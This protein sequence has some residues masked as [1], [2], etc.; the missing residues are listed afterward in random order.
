M[1]KSRVAPVKQLS[2]PQLELIAGLLGA[3]LAGHVRRS[4]T[5]SGDIETTMWSDSQIVLHW[6]K[7]RRPLKQ[8]IAN[9]VKEINQLT[10]GYS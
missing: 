7:T 3:R 9:R 1:A 4:L 2:L 8:F 10:S 6:L 5:D